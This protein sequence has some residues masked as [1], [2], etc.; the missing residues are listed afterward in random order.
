MV[1]KIKREIESNSNDKLESW[2]MQTDILVLEQ[3]YLDWV[4]RRKNQNHRCNK[5]W[6]DSGNARWFCR[7]LINARNRNK[8]L[9]KKWEQNL[10][11]APWLNDSQFL[12]QLASS[13]H[14]SK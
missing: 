14:R 12:S 11:N 5:G 2:A 3:E 13:L 1:Y 6:Y 8:E 4:F 10:L 9:N 7:H